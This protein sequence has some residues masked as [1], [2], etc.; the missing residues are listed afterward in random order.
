MKV[1]AKARQERVEKVSE[2]QYKVWVKAAPEKGKANEAVVEALS[3]CLGIPKSRIKIVS[4][5]TST[6]KTFEV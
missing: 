4:G 5:Q 2:G 1:K 6:Q 3:E